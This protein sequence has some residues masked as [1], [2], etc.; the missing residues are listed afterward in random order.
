MFGWLGEA[1]AKATRP[2][3]VPVIQMSHNGCI[4]FGKVE[5]GPSEHPALAFRT[6]HTARR[7]NP[8]SCKRL[9]LA[10]STSEYEP[11]SL[12]MCS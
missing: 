3:R 5:A 8:V 12:S 11:T 7:E 4:P 1:T 6:V 2:C 9:R 10:Y